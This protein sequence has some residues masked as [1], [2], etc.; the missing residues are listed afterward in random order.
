MVVW[1]DY[2]YLASVNGR[3]EPALASVETL[4][5]HSASLSVVGLKNKLRR[6]STLGSA[7]PL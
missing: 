1:R 2:L 3:S 5:G 6:L 4:S 7:Y